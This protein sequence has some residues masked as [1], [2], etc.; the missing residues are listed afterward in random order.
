VSWNS[1]W[2]SDPPA[3]GIKG[4]HSSLPLSLSFGGQWVR[5]EGGGAA[6]VVNSCLREE[7]DLG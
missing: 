6:G 1:L 3:A 7:L 2:N 5:L 4:V